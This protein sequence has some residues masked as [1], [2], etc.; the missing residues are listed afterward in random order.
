[1][2]RLRPVAKHGWINVGSVGHAEWQPAGLPEAYGADSIEP[3]AIFAVGNGLPVLGGA[4]SGI[5]GHSHT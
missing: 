1:M 4:W 2:R 5:R 3:G